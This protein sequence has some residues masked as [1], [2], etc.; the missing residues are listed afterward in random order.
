[1]AST[2]VAVAGIVAT[3]LP[4][5]LPLIEQGIDDL[6]S[7]TEPA[8]KRVINSVID[9]HRKKVI[10]HLR[11]AGASPQ[12][13]KEWNEAFDS[14]KRIAHEH[15]EKASSLAR[16]NPDLGNRLVEHAQRLHEANIAKQ[17]EISGASIPEPTPEI[18]PPAMREI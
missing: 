6:K 9:T 4:V 2:A 16:I 11:S 1:M 3:L 8:I 5:I 17:R 13:I 14:I 10:A 12:T 7:I 18:S 15:V